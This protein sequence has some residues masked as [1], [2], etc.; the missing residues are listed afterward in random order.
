VVLP[1]GIILKFVPLNE[2]PIKLP[3]LGESHQVAKNPFV[4]AFKLTGL[5]HEILVGVHV[6]LVGSVGVSILISTSVLPP[7]QGA[8][9]HDMVN[10]PFPA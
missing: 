2:V 3:P 5:P 10:C 9:F 8:T 6:T 1:V 4:E 7:K